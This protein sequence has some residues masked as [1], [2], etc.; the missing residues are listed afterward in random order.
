[1]REGGNEMEAILECSALTKRFGEKAALDG[2]SASFAGGRITG[3]LGPNGSGKTTLMKLA[4]GLLMPTGGAVRVCGQAPGVGTKTQTAYLPDRDYLP[5]YLSV[6]DAVELFGDFYADFDREKAE[7]LLDELKLTAKERVGAMSKG[8]REKLQMAL[9]MSRKAKLFLLDEPLGGVDPAAR[10]HIL[11]TIIRNYSEDAAL[12]ISTHLIGDVETILDD[13]VMIENGK[14]CLSG[15]AEALRAEHG[16]S[17]D[18]LFR[19]GFR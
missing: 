17:I 16:K 8:T 12:V 11:D 1:M 5:H 6:Q 10:D 15:D 4:A 13:V 2:F 7:T 9:V 3:L 14:V 19:E 18:A